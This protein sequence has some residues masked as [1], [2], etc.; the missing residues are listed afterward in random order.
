[1]AIA[2]EGEQYTSNMETYQQSII[3]AR[4]NAESDGGL[5]RVDHTGDGRLKFYSKNGN[6]W[7]V[8]PGGVPGD[9]MQIW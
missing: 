4:N 6:S 9:V 7:E 1:M 8:S 2:P 5:L 3:T